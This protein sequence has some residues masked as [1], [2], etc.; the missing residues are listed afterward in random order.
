MK[1]EIL[2][3]SDQFASAVLNGVCQGI[4]VAAL[5]GIGLRLIGRTN[6]ATRH[7]VWFATLL[8]LVL[9]IP[10][11][12]LRNQI[13]SKAQD[14]IGRADEN[15][16]AENSRFQLQ[17]RGPAEVVAARNANSSEV[18]PPAAPMPGIEATA[19]SIE[20]TPSIFDQDLAFQQYLRPDETASP[21]PSPAPVG[22]IGRVQI[23]VPPPVQSSTTSFEK[24]DSSNLPAHASTPGE[25]HHWGEFP[26]SWK[27]PIG[28]RFPRALS[29]VLLGVWLAVAM[30]RITILIWRLFQLRK[31]KNISSAPGAVLRELFQTLA[32]RLGVRRRAELK[33]S[34]THRSPAL[35]G[36]F[37][38]VVLLPAQEAGDVEQAEHVLSHELAHVRRRDD[39]ANLVQHF[40]RAALF[41]HPG[42]WWISR[43]LSLEREIAC[44]DYVL[45]QGCRP[46]AY[47]LLLANLASRMKGRAPLLAPAASTT[48]SQLKQR[49]TMILNTQRNTSPRLAKTRLGFIT[50]AA[51][52]LAVAAIYSGPRL[53]LAQSEPSPEAVPQAG[54]V[55]GSPDGIEPPSTPPQPVALAAA[56]GDKPGATPRDVEPGPKFKP[57][58]PPEP[59]EPGE[60]APLAEP[61]PPA[62]P[63]PSSAEA[64]SVSPADLQEED[65]PRLERPNREPRPPRAPRPAF[66]RKGDSSLEERLDRLEKMVESLMAQQKPNHGPGEMKFRF[67]DDAKVKPNFNRN[68]AEADEQKLWAEKA[69]KEADKASKD[70]RGRAEKQMKEA[71]QRE[72]E[73]LR[74]ARESLQREMEKLDRQIERLEQGRKAAVL[75]LQQNGAV[76][77]NVHPVPVA[78]V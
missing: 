58:Q 46:Q 14:T 29:L 56:E 25:T 1:I 6:A 76:A 45:G 53:V 64:V 36:F 27:L 17:G 11:Q 22:E 5:V 16:R 40:I 7:A 78:R 26:V 35:L 10:A 49:I 69:A 34:S 52:V 61:A 23:S 24:T 55:S 57:G 15:S 9:I 2:E 63:A 18:L 32:G 38:P 21:E 77:V 3:A 62:I 73:A 72:L 39:W 44:D 30:A 20:T 51:V 37:H 71:S 74:R 48:K 47:A 54:A 4:I 50:S 66:N 41:F 13:V 65:G 68:N 31:L 60:N 70:E 43:Q 67:N 59:P 42:V 8:L 28:S 75:E 33:I 12:C 19:D